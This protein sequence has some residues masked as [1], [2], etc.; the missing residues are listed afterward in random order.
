MSFKHPHVAKSFP[1][2]VGKRSF[3]FRPLL[4]DFTFTVK[5]VELGKEISRA[6]PRAGFIF[7]WDTCNHMLST[8]LL[9]W[10]QRKHITWRLIETIQCLYI[11]YR[12]SQ[13]QNRPSKN[14]PFKLLSILSR[15]LSLYLDHIDITSQGLTNRVV[16]PISNEQFSSGSF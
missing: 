14:I 10:Q 3:N 12:T 11:I 16:G 1:R 6:K 8:Q 7:D 9:L 13:A 15:S 5:S 2:A 4:G